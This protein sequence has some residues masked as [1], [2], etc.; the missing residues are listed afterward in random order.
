VEKRGEAGIAP[1]SVAGLV[2]ATIVVL[3]I[4]ELQR[5]HR[6]RQRSVAG[7]EQEMHMIGHAD[8]RMQRHA[9]AVAV[10]L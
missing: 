5:L 1:E 2:M 8:I 3:T 10:A 4:G 7:L 6:A 9:V